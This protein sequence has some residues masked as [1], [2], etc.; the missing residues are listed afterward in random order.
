MNKTAIHLRQRRASRAKHRGF[1][2]IEVLLS[3]TVLGV[4]AAAVISMERAVVQGNYDARR[5][6]VATSIGR[7]WLDRLRRDS[8]SW[9]LPNPHLA[10][11]Q[12]TLAGSSNLSA[13]KW[14]NV[15]TR[16]A[17]T[18][19]F[20]GYATATT[21][22]SA[23]FDALGRDLQSTE[24]ANAI[25]CVNYRV[26]WLD[27]PLTA[28]ALSNGLMRAEVRV[29]WQRQIGLGS[30]TALCPADMS[31]VNVSNPNQIFQFVYLT[32]AIR[33]NIQL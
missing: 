21:P 16:P 25:Y 12:P 7:M 31:D 19:F 9:T 1:S 2:A 29:Y 13:T 18:W 27:Y 33:E 5:L 17:T 8:L 24:L 23:A 30:T 20:P 15:V 28:T 32:T 26:E 11:S 6:D 10:Q 4:G 14:L 3:M 22:E